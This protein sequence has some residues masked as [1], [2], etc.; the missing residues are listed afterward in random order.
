M[1]RRKSVLMLLCLSLNLN[2]M[3]L[4]LIAITTKTKAGTMLKQLILLAIEGNDSDVDSGN[5]GKR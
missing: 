2:P 1:K 3:D 5:G 4:N